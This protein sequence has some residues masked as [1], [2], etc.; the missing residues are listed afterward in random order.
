M[1]FLCC[2]TVDEEVYEE[3]RMLRRER[4]RLLQKIKV[5]EQQQSS[6]TIALEEVMHYVSY[7]IEQ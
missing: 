3:I 5:L 6:A 7:I 2:K 1:F 4:G